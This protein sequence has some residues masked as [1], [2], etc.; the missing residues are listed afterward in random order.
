MAVA[1]QEQWRKSDYF[2]KRNVAEMDEPARV[3]FILD[4]LKTA[5]DNQDQ[6]I[7]AAYLLQSYKRNRFLVQ[8]STEGRR[9]HLVDVPAPD[10]RKIEVINLMLGNSQ[11]RAANYSSIPLGWLCQRGT[12]FE[13]DR[14]SA[15]I[16]TAKANGLL[17]RKLATR[18]PDMVDTLIWYGPMA[19]KVGMDPNGGL[20]KR[21]PLLSETPTPFPLVSKDNVKRGAKQL[22]QVANEDTGLPE[23]TVERSGFPYFRVLNVLEFRVDP[24]ATSMED[25]RWCADVVRVDASYLYETFWSQREKLDKYE[26]WSHKLTISD[27]E[28]QVRQLKKQ[29]VTSTEAQTALIVDF[30]HRPAPNLGLTRGLHTVFAYDGESGETS[31]KNCVVLHWSPLR[32]PGKLPLYLVGGEVRDSKNLSGSAYNQYIARPQKAANLM[33]TLSLEGAQKAAGVIIGLPGD[34]KSNEVSAHAISTTPR[35]MGLYFKNGDP[36]N[37]E[38]FGVGEGVAVQDS[39]FERIG[40]AIET[41]TNTHGSRVGEERLASLVVRNLERQEGV[42]G[43]VKNDIV[44][45][46]Q[47]AMIHALQLIQYHLVT[48]ECR[49]LVPDYERDEVRRW[50]GADL[51]SFRLELKTTT[52]LSNNLAMQLELYKAMAQYGEDRTKYFDPDIIRQKFNLAA[53]LGRTP[54]DVHWEKAERE[55]STMRKRMVKPEDGENHEVHLK[56]HDLEWQGPDRELMSDSELYRKR[57]HMQLHRKMMAVEQQQQLT[58]LL[59]AQAQAK[60]ATNPAEAGATPTPAARG[61]EE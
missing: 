46:C 42:L 5:E 36:K 31:D 27:A 32:Y 15:E 33:H 20:R 56:V 50:R 7:Q 24:A 54:R 60:A 26:A 51:D 58:R 19:L 10:G 16:T 34:P 29:S 44:A 41:I 9:K 28:A 53:Q 12:G 43:L 21:S 38:K 2:D 39:L 18:L 52:L 4:L 40:T 59:T 61:A 47:G 35:V 22:Y 23:Y 49:A 17:G 13:D 30:Y 3:G 45:A 48:D 57:L 55:R 11:L 8:H 14:I 25:A 6:A 37:V 1:L